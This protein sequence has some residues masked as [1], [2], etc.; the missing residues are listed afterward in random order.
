M[1]RILGVTMTRQNVTN[2]TYSDGRG[3][4]SAVTGTTGY[5]PDLPVRLSGALLALAI[6]TVHVAD[7]GGIT[8]MASPS[9]IGWSYRLIE[10]GGVLTALALII[11]WRTLLSRSATLSR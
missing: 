4:M 6:S 1:L 10:V 7:Q 5:M 11:P 9:W 3:T 8:A 2:R